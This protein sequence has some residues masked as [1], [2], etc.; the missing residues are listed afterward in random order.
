[1]S[2]YAVRHPHDSPLHRADRVQVAEDHRHHRD[3]TR[4]SAIRFNHRYGRTFPPPQAAIPRAAARIADLQEPDKKMSTSAPNPDG[5]LLVL[6]EPDTI[7]RKLKRAVTDSGSEIVAR[8]DK[9]GVTNLLEI[10]SA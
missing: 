2:A 8:E 1:Q 9:P 4:D 10:M 7:R 6:D 3:L 5:K